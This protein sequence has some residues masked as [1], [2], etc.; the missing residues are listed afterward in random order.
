MLQYVNSFTCTR[1]E[2]TGT[3]IIHFN[4]NE[5]IVA[6]TES[7]LDTVIKEHEIAS[8]VLE[9]DCIKALFSSL[10]DLFDNSPIEIE[11]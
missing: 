6:E 11:E 10:A 2:Q 1:N 4:Q 7:G 3:V 8:I 9:E 5:P